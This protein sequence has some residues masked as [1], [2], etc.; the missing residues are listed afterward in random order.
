VSELPD[1]A[2]FVI[3]RTFTRLGDQA[4][5]VSGPRLWNSLLSNLRQSDLTV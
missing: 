3:P 4:F 1:T 2:A 5:P